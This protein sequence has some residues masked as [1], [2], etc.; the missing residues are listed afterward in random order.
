MSVVDVTKYRCVLGVLKT[1][2]GLRIKE[3]M[4]KWLSEKYE[5]IAVEQEAPGDLYELPGLLMAAELSYKLK[6]SVLYLHTKG[7]AMQN[8]AQPMVRKCWEIE[9][10]EK[11]DKYFGIANS[12][13]KPTVVAPVVAKENKVCW[14][15][16]FVMNWQAAYGHADTGGIRDILKVQSDRMWFEQGMLKDIIVDVVSPY[17][18]GYAEKP[19]EAW[20]CFVNLYKKLWADHQPEHK[21]VVRETRSEEDFAVCAIA[22]DEEPYIEEWLNYY[23][24]I[25]C[26]RFYLLDNNDVGNDGLLDIVKKQTSYRGES[27]ISWF[28]LR[29]R[30]RLRAAGYQGGCYAQIFNMFRTRHK[31]M[32]FFDIDEFLNLNGRTWQEWAA[33]F[34]EIANNSIIQFNWRYF[35]DNGLVHYENKPVRE[36]FTVPCP[37]DVK[38]AQEFPENWYVK[39]IVNCNAGNIKQHLIHTAILDAPMKVVNSVGEKMNIGA[40]QNPNPNYINGCIDHYGTKTIE[41]YVKKRCLCTNWA[42]NEQTHSA[43]KRIEWFFNVNEDTPEK[44]DV[45]AKMITKMMEG[46]E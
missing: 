27:D 4:L 39:P 25:G 42:V 26:K 44:R 7:A 21:P 3:E 43:D 12:T 1:P 8:N 17:E 23:R 15:N 20:P 46:R 28:D 16:G 32:G 31:Y 45:I 24:S 29:G 40:G 41:E 22:K 2:E 38:Y 5:V 9:F 10:G 33:A 19:E 36:R 18:D 34:P 6:E 37:T 35:G 13:T 14:F 30:D 11:A